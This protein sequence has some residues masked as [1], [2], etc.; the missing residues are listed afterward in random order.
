M[1]CARCGKESAR[2]ARH[3]RQWVC[4]ACHP[5]IVCLN[6]GADA[7]PI[8]IQRFPTGNVDSDRYSLHQ[9]VQYRCAIG[10]LAEGRIHY[11]PGSRGWTDAAEEENPP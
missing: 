2:V 1:N 5:T 4:A 8:G 6:C 3:E 7:Q 10:H 9:A 11:G